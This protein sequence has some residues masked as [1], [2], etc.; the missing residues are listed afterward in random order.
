M[1]VVRTDESLRHMDLF[2]SL[3]AALALDNKQTRP[4]IE[5][6]LIL[7]VE[8]SQI[9]QQFPQWLSARCKQM[10][11]SPS[12]ICL[13]LSVESLSKDLRTVSPILRQFNRHGIRLMLEGVASS[14][15][16]RMMQNIA[17]FDYL[18]VSGR[19]IN[20]SF[21][22]LSERMELEAIIAVA[23]EHHCE[24]CSGGV[25]SQVMLAHAL[26]MNIEIGFGRECG[27]SIAFPEQTWIRAES[28]D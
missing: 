4:V 18:Y 21:T 17:H 16:F 12:D 26:A 22:K 11:V 28:L 20:D 2:A 13:S 19:A 3:L 7:Q 24:I 23:R 8:A 5:S 9:D 27:A 1:G 14:N 10:R 25:D 15:Q 6:Q